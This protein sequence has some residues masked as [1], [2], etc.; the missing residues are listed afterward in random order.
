MTSSLALPLIVTA[1]LASTLAL[2]ALGR[3]APASGP[4]PTP[5]APTATA[6]VAVRGAT[7]PG[8]PAGAPLG[9]W[10]WPL[11]PVPH[12][13]RRFVLGP[14]PWSRGHRGVDLAARPGQSVLAPADGVIAWRGPVAGRPVVVLVHGSRLRTTYEPVTAV[15]PPGTVVIRGQ[16]IG[17]VVRSSASHCRPDSCLHWG[18]LYGSAYLDP[19]SLLGGWSAEVVLLPP[20]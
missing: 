1:L 17:T 6:G 7:G 19:L 5:R 10:A 18:A 14:Q 13:V 12:V 4:T 8:V 15:S 3:T 20:G 2:P 16:P 9:R 11:Q